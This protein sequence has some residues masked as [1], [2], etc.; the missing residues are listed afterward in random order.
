MYFASKKN[1]KPMKAPVRKGRK[2]KLISPINTKRDMITLEIIR[3][4]EERGE[5]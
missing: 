2:E 5:M 3:Y 4:L 1:A